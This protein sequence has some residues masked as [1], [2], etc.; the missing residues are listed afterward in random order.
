MARVRRYDVD[1]G[2]LY[3]H[4]IAEKG[5]ALSPMSGEGVRSLASDN[6]DVWAD[7]ASR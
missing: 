4:V 2:Q 7:A 1:R 3:S 5:E 6:G